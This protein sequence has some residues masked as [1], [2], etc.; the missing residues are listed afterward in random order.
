MKRINFKCC[1][2]EKKALF[3]LQ[4]RTNHRPRVSGDK[5]GCQAEVSLLGLEQFFALLVPQLEQFFSQGLRG[6]LDAGKKLG[7]VPHTSDFRE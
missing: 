4:K 7:K 1:V 5:R 6:A 2:Q 3:G